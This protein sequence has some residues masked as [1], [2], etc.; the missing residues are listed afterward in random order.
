MN[1]VEKITAE[2]VHRHFDLPAQIDAATSLEKIREA[3]IEKLNFFLDHD[4]EKLLWILYRVDVSEQKAKAAL[5][6]KSDHPP[7]EVL[8]DLIIQRQLQKAETRLKY[9]SGMKEN[10]DDSFPEH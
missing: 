9:R 1:E 4:F 2:M 6:E 10:E 8:A 3:L 5:A 7:A